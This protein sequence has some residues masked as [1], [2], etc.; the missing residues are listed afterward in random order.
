[1]E[2]GGLFSWE[3][4]KS[5]PSRFTRQSYWV[6]EISRNRMHDLWLENAKNTRGSTL[7]KHLPLLLSGL[8]I[9][10]LVA[11]AT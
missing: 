9:W 4:T 7:M 6:M 11:F 10:T 8:N 5:L 1:M 2:V 3:E